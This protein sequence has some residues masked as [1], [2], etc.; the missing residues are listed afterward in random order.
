MNRSTQYPAARMAFSAEPQVAKRILFRSWFD[1]GSAFARFSN[2]ESAI[3]HDFVD[4]K[5]LS[6]EDLHKLRA[7]KQPD[8]TVNKS[9]TSRELVM[10]IYD[11]SK[12]DPYLSPRG[13]MEIAKDAVD[14]LND[15]SYAVSDVNRSE[16]HLRRCFMDTVTGGISW[17]KTGR[18]MDP[19]KEDIWEGRRDFRDIIPDPLFQEPDYSDARYLFDGQWYDVDT[20]CSM[21]PM[22]KAIFTQA[23]GRNST[24]QVYSNSPYGLNSDIVGDYPSRTFMY[25]GES[26]FGWR[27]DEW[28]DRSNG[29]VLVH[30]LWYYQP[31]R[32]RFLK[33]MATSELIEVPMKD[34]DLTAEQ[35]IAIAAVVN[36]GAPI[37]LVVGPINRCRRAIICGPHILEDGP[38]P[39]RHNYIP[40]VPFTAYR[41]FRN[42]SFSGL[43]RYF[44]KPQQAFNRAFIKLLHTLAT[45]QVLM[46][47]GAG[48]VNTVRR[49]INDPS[50]VIQLKDGALQHKKIQIESHLADA[51]MHLAVMSTVDAMMG[52]LAGGLE[53]KGGQTNADSGRAIALR[54]QQGNLTLSTFFEMFYESKRMLVEQRIS[55]IQQYWDY[56]KWVRMTGSRMG[57]HQTRQINVPNLQGGID[58]D[59]TRFRMDVIYDRQAAKSGA[60]Q[61]FAD[62]IMEL[63]QRMPPFMIAEY[64]PLVT[65]LYDLPHREEISQISEGIIQKYGLVMAGQGMAG[66]AG[67]M[68]MA[69][70]M[71][72]MTDAQGNNNNPM[73]PAAASHELASTA[74]R[75]ARR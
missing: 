29:R 51:Q 53:L 60:R 42:G 7:R 43:I 54:Q 62:R 4:D 71:D 15:A 13:D 10:G 68:P 9:L 69:G 28:S 2:E 36:S 40:Y 20:A 33:N 65:K 59:I 70:P 1:E 11:S 24:L 74:G 39:Y 34:S 64:M 27:S 45:R 22:Y 56:P 41:D 18:N 17:M 66:G 75:A 72:V 21:W 14:A 3:D 55:L 26:T 35:K 46:E 48:D 58:N 16:R 57:V 61:A 25:S 30:E 19:T 52:D 47:K 32:A 73:N 44:R 63:M 49:Q 12:M 8:T 5:Q 23:T 6:P 38:S 50:A 67:G 37:R 31:D